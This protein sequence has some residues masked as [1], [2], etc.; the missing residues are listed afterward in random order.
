[1]NLVEHDLLKEMQSAGCQAMFFGIESGSDAVLERI[2]KDFTAAEA[3]EALHITLGYMRPVASFIWGFPFET[4]DDLTDTLLLMLYLSQ[5]GVDCRLS[6]LAPFPLMPLYEEYGDTITWCAER[7]S[8]PGRL[9]FDTT[10]YPARVVEL[11][12]QH[13]KIFPSFYCFATDHFAEKARR[14]AALG[15]FWQTT[16]WSEERRERL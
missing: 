3:V 9:P 4:E 13:P 7:G 1:V 14:V 12:R 16:S 8:H 6:R 2:T 5:V 15:S 11:I 10:G